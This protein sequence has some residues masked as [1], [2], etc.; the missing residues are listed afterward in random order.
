[1]NAVTRIQIPDEAVGISHG[2]YTLAKGMNPTILPRTMGKIVD[3]TGLFSLCMVT[4]LGEGKLISNQ[5]NSVLK[6]L[7]LC[8]ILHLQRGWVNIYYHHYIFTVSL[9]F[10]YDYNQ[11]LSR[12]VDLGVM[13]TKVYSTLLRTPGLKPHH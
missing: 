6:K 8:R 9:Q 5:L 11:L 10:L 3:Q 12:R 1:M 13:A 4:G 2:A 7:T